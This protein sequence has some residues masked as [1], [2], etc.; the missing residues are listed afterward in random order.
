MG[1]PRT[2]KEMIAYVWDHGGPM[3]EDE[4]DDLVK[5]LQAYWPN[6]NFDSETVHRRARELRNIR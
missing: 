6:K 3:R 1:E 5:W 2:V 4:G